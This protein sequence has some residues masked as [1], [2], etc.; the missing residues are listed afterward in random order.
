[1]RNRI[2]LWLSLFTSTSTLFCCA[3]P[4]LF[5]LLGLGA[6]FAGLTGSFPQLVWLSENKEWTFLF[7]GIMLS[8]GFILPRM[9]TPSEDIACTVTPDGAT[10]CSTTGAWSR[11][12][13]FVSAGLYSIGFFF[14]YIAPRLP[15]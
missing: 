11:K 14:A 13:W 1:M 2:L 12:L 4:A 7:G 3:L 10:A 15:I 9:V 6:S 8:L 5:V